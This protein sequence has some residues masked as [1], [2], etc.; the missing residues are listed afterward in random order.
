ML[1]SLLTCCLLAA[2]EGK[3]FL[4]DGFGSLRACRPNVLVVRLSSPLAERLDT[5]EGSDEA[6]ACFLRA[7]ATVTGRCP[8]LG[9]VL[10]RLGSGEDLPSACLR[11]GAMPE[12]R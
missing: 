11:M 8:A 4:A 1:V 6:S 5:P 7:G 2:P 10:V 3:L 12:V 9:M